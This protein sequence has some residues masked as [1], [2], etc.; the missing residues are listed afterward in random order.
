MIQLYNDDCFNILSQI[1]D[2][3]VDLILIDPPYNTLSNCKSSWDKKIDF[4]KLFKE[5]L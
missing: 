5:Y 2:K 4:E 1:P 3:N